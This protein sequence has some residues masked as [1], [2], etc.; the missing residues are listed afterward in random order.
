[1]NEFRKHVGCAVRVTHEDGS[2]VVGQL[3]NVGPTTCWLLC[4]T[5]AAVEDVFVAHANIAGMVAL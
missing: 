4:A 5:S 1:V 3:H 2:E